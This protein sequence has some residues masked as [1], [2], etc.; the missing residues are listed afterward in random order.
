MDAI[1]KQIQN[2]LEQELYSNIVKV[3]DLALTIGE[4]KP[5]SFT[6]LIKLQITLY[7]ADALYNTQQYFQAENLYRQALQMRKNIIIKKSTNNKMSDSQNEVASDVDIKYKIHLCCL[8][9]KQKKAA[10]EILQMISARLRTPKVNM[11]LGNI[12]KELGMER[13]A[14]ACFK[15][16]LRECPLALEAV[17]NLLKLGIKGVEVNALVVEVS[18]E[19]TWLSSWIRAQAQI[20]SRDFA[21]AI[22][23]YK[24]MDTHGLLKDNTSLLISMGYCYHYMCE[25]HRAISILQKAFRIDPF[26]TAGKDLLSTLLAASGTKD[27]IR[28]LESLAPTMDMSLWTSEHWVVLGNYMYALKKYDKA[29][30]FGQQACLLDRRNVEA[31]LLKANTLLQIKKYQDAASHCTEALQICPYRY[32]LYKCLVECYIQ[33]SRLR[34][35]ESMAMNACKQLNFSAQGYCLHATVL[36]K[37]PMASSKTVRRTLEKAVSQ[38]KN[39]STNALCMLVEFLDQEQ[40]YDQASQLLL[41]HIETLKPSSRLHQ[42]L[43]D[44]FVNLQKDDEAFQH[45]TIALKLDPS[46]QRATEGLNNIGRSLSLGKR[47]SYYTCAA[48]E[49][50][51][52]SQGTNPSDHEVDPESDTDPWPPTDNVDNFE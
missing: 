1:I 9:L 44:C 30:Y 42:L 38:D 8:A 31:L 17:E 35:A 23:T 11:A 22:K 7:Y 48:G 34:E 43:G 37:D 25:D 13:S 19:M 2:L 50:S 36:L 52:A 39:G 16:V 29:A 46:N 6:L 40:Q 45:Y 51:Y 26:L 49:T 4:Q 18:S 14:I 20:N 33:T 15:E 5:E 47:D 24:S 10:G 3:S 12:Y 21:N 27:H 41:K 32:D 28:T